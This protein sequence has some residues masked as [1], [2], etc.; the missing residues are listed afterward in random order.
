MEFLT[1]NLF[2][3][4]IAGPE[5]ILDGVLVV[6]SMEVEKVHTVSL[7]ALKGGLQLRAHTFWLQGLPIPGVGFGSNAYCCT[8]NIS[9]QKCACYLCIYY[10]CK[11]VN[12][13]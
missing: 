7:Q 6:R 5:S 8:E 1:L 3:Q 10:I 11:T 12:T 13:G 4:L 9:K 2:V